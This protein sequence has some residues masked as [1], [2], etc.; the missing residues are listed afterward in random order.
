[1]ST[2][3]PRRKRRPKHAEPVAAETVQVT[4]RYVRLGDAEYEVISKGGWALWSAQ[5]APGFKKPPGFTKHGGRGYLRPIQ[6]GEQ[7]ECYRITHRGTYLGVAV[8]LHPSTEGRVM[9]TSRDQHARDVGFEPFDRDEWVK[10]IPLDDP[11]LRFTTIR[12][13][14]VGPWMNAATA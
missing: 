7:L 13:P 12:A 11:E 10:L 5:P 1:M 2:R 4:G 9:A 8:S 3:S 6:P 14:E